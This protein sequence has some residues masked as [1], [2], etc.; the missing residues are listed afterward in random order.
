M[1]IVIVKGEYFIPNST[2]N[3]HIVNKDIKV[4]MKIINI[5]PHSA[6]DNFVLFFFSKLKNSDP[7]KKYKTFAA[8]K[9]IILK[10]VLVFIR[11]SVSLFVKTVNIENAII[12]VVSIKKTLITDKNNFFGG[13]PFKAIKQ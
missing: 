11:N 1:D 3:F 13:F 8:N 7:S 9:T 2:D 6:I 5:T 10:N 12:D 4:I